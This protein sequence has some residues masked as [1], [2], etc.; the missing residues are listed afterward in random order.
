MEPRDNYTLTVYANEE[1]ILDI[2]VSEVEA[3]LS[4]FTRV[5]KFFSSELIYNADDTN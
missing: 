5:T 2:G 3:D 4:L 1:H